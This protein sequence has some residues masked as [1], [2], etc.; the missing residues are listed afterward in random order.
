MSA[1][2]PTTQPTNRDD[3]AVAAHPEP[4]GQPPVARLASSTRPWCSDLDA[5]VL[6][7]LLAVMETV[8]ND[9]FAVASSEGLTPPQAFLLRLIDEPLPMR[10]LA[11]LLGY[12]ASNITAIADKLEGRGAVER[13]P[14]PDDR[15]VKRLALTPAGRQ[16]RD[17][18][19]QR[20]HEQVSVV[21]HLDDGA[22]A[23]LRDL[24]RS[25]VDG[26]TA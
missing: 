2:H 25:A 12:D 14:D 8:K 3:D 19:E 10:E 21:A 24:L 4:C 7:V 22:K 1:T 17:R 20:L 18:L 15:R 6:E 16:L 11:D 9:F 26:P 23:R 13:Q 5:E